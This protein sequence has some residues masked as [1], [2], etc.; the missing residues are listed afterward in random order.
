[1]VGELPRIREALLTID[2]MSVIV[3]VIDAAD[4]VDNRPE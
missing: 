1:M 4:P 3:G 2:T